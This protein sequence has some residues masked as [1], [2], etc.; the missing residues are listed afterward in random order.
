[1]KIKKINFKKYI[2]QIIVVIFFI[3]A[4]CTANAFLKPANLMNILRSYSMVGVIAFGMT[5]TIIGGEIDLAVGSTVAFSGVI[6]AKIAGILADS[7]ILPL[8]SG[9]VF[10]LLAALGL[11]LLVG[12]LNGVLVVKFK[13]PSFIVT[14]GMLN[15][16]YG[17]S[18]VISGGFSLTTFPAWYSWFGAGQ[19]CGFLPSGVLF[20]LLAFVVTL[21]ILKYTNFGCAVY[22]VGG[23]ADAARL[24]GIKV[25]KVKIIIM[26]IVEFCAGLAGIILSSQTLS[27]NFTYGKGWE[28]DVISSVIIG[29]ASLSGGKGSAAG[30]LIGILFLGILNNAM[31]LWGVDDYIK[32]IV[33]GGLVIGAV[34]LNTIVYKKSET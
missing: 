29:G 16:L 27:A 9:M 28:M 26:M 6:A 4:A 19:I 17:I 21:V 31:T 15:L 10:G 32:Y 1:M 23:N 22:A 5:F 2:L 33:Q 18:A 11:S 24:S 34:L 13:M 3:I 8:E 30:S 7:N 14:L 25:G 20:L 12:F